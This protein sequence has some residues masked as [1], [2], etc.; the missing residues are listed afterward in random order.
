[1]IINEFRE[2]ECWNCGWVFYKNPLCYVPDEE[3]DN[4]PLFFTKKKNLQVAIIS[5]GSKCR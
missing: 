5:E 1:M 3:L 4:H 2:Y